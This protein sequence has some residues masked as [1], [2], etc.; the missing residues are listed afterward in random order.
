MRAVRGS[1]V[2]SFRRVR[3]GSQRGWTLPEMLVS[4]LV[5]TM[6]LGAASTL[7]TGVASLSGTTDRETQ[8]QD[9]ARTTIDALS[10]QLRNAAGPPGKSPIYSPAAGSSG[11]ATELIFYQPVAGASTTNNP[12]GLQWV[13]YCLDFSSLTN[14]KLWMQTF[15]Y[16]S[17]Q[18]APPSTASCPSA[19]WTTQQLVASNIV[20]KNTSPVTTL[21]TQGEDVSG[22]IRDIQVRLVVQGDSARKPTAITSSLQFRNLKSAPSAVLTCTAQNGHA[23]CDASRSSD[24]DGEA[25]TFQWKY[26]CCSPSFASGDATWETGQTSYIFDK[27]GLT[28]GNTYAIYVEVTNGSGVFTDASQQVTMP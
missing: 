26:R 4:V 14:E 9:K 11:G 13:R 25:L 23:V 8:A 24:P 1:V 19:S 15:A 10:A 12:R 20:N 18:S 3:L 16:D 27:S 28:S 5:S 2:S 21:F 17:T 7:V 6:V 22:A